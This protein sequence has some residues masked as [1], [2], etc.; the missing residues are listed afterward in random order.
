MVC[1]LSSTALTSTPS[2]SR[3]PTPA[4]RS[5][6]G[7]SS[8]LRL[9]SSSSRL[10]CTRVRSISARLPPPA[11]LGSWPSPLCSAP[12]FPYYVVVS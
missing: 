12:Y 5:A 10:L 3:A 11:V 4:P 6:L 1:W 8:S 2:G 7:S 9:K